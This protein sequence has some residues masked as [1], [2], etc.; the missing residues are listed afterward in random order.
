MTYPLLLIPF[1]FNTL[2]SNLLS[3]KRLQN[4]LKTEE[5]ETGKYQNNEEYNKNVLIKFDNVSFGIHKNQ[6]KN[7]KKKTQKKNF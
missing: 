6:I 7:K 3:V 4:F 5:F 2:F 1:F